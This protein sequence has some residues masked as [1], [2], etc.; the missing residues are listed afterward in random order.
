MAIVQSY[1]IG[2]NTKTQINF[3]TDLMSVFHLI[4]PEHGAYSENVKIK[5]SKYQSKSTKNLKNCYWYR[6]DLLL[7]IKLQTLNVQNS[8]PDSNKLD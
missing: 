8:K 1:S 2:T 6:A 4:F 7:Y 5:I 3:R